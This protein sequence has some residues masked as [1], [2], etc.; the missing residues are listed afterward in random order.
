MNV[1]LGQISNE[2][3]ATVFPIL[4]AEVAHSTT[5]V[6]DASS[7]APLLYAV[8]AL[9]ASSAK[10]AALEK[11]HG[12]DRIFGALVIALVEAHQHHPEPV[13]AFGNQVVT[14]HGRKLFGGEAQAGDL[15]REKG[16][17]IWDTKETR[18]T[19]R[20][21]QAE[22]GRWW[23]LSPLGGSRKVLARL[24]VRWPGH[25]VGGLHI[26]MLQPSVLFLP[27]LAAHPRRWSFRVVT[28]SVGTYTHT[29]MHTHIHTYIHTYI[30]IHTHTYT[31]T[32]TYMR[33]WSSRV[34]T[35]SVGTRG[36][37]YTARKR[38]TPLRRAVAV[39]RAVAAK[40]RTAKCPV[41]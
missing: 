4:K 28:P 20:K 15:Y 36:S 16:W 25:T 12:K 37:G 7:Y 2:E 5:V 18:V 19:I 26:L 32:Y 8:E 31:Y 11:H 13:K 29:H 39:L 38:R 6:Y 9:S 3:F 22:N 33:R 41:K 27:T 30:H 24:R 14:E 1:V 21:E 17:T 40:V 10:V 35:Q 34:A 23:Y